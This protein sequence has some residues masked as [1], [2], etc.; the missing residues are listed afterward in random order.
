MGIRDY[1]WKNKYA[2]PG[3]NTVNDK[4]NSLP[5]W[6]A[7]YG[8]LK[9]SLPSGWKDWKIWQYGGKKAPGFKGIIDHNY[10]KK[11]V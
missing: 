11:E 1:V 7:H 6:V 3:E 9:P 4:I 5:L 2:Q 8:V 10:R